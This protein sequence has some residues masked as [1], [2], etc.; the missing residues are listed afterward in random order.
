MA[1]RD[2][3]LATGDTLSRLDR[4]ADAEQHFR[5][6][7][8]AFPD[9]LRAWASLATV[10][11]AQG[12]AVDA[13]AAIDALIAAVPTPEGYGVA[14]RVLTIIGDRPRAERLRASG[15]QKFKGDPAIKLLDAPQVSS[16]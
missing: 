14:A 8:R 4:F 13:A 9:N 6:E 11:N 5:N 3:Q 7:L 12:R 16:F 15:R 1:V 2:L 10:Y